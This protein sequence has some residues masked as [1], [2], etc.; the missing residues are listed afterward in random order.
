MRD[1]PRYVVVNMMHGPAWTQGRSF[2]VM[3]GDDPC[4]FSS[5][6]D[7]IYQLL[8]LMEGRGHTLETAKVYVLKPLYPEEIR[9]ALERVRP[10][11]EADRDM[12]IG[13]EE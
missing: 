3:P 13:E 10:K 4:A 8:D 1:I 2:Y 7:A 6:D 5:L 9:D 11:Y 12:L